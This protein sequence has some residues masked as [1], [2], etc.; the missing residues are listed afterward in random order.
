MRF[1]REIAYQIS[2]GGPRGL[3]LGLSAFE[4][5]EQS[6]IDGSLRHSTERS[7]EI[8][9]NDPDYSQAETTAPTD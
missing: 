3:Y 1:C 7:E 5:E 4:S 9:I 6:P 8:G 2:L